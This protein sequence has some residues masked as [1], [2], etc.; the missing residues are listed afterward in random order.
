MENRPRKVLLAEDE[1]L[2][3]RAAETALRQRGYTVLTATDGAEALQAA[4]TERPD[5]ILLD[6]I[7]PRVRGCEVLRT[8]KKDP[9]TAPVP[10]IV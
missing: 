2:L 5:L 8:L 1:R 4:R 10:V 3:R 7:M 9:R 6:L